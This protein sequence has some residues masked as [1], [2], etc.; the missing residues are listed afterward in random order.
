MKRVVI[1]SLFLC[2]G[3]C[4]G[5]EVEC[6]S[7]YFQLENTVLNNSANRYQILKGYLPLKHETGPACVTS[8]YYI[9]M[10]SSD[11]VNQS[12]PTD[13]KQDKMLTCC[14]KWKWCTNSFYMGLDLSQLQD[15]SFHILIN[16]TTET[17]LTLP[18]VCNSIKDD[19]NEYLLRITMLV[20]G[21]YFNT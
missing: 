19:L 8:Y 5:Q 4:N 14:S 16:A 7:D 13:I 3:W 20:R 15:F 12:C 2:L 9:G 6:I 21:K 10:N 17:K 18:P 1:I 11:I